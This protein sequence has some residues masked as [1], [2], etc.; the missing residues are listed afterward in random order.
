MKWLDW[1]PN[2]EV[3]AYPLSTPMATLLYSGGVLLGINGERHQLMSV[4]V[5]G[6]HIARDTSMSAY[7]GA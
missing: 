2:V 1:L 5:I 4:R 3:S 7:V 6:A